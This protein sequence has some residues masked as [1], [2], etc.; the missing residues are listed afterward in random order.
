MRKTCP[1]NLHMGY[2]VGLSAGEQIATGNREL[3]Q[4]D[5]FRRLEFAAS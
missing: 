5:E 4:C 3:T 2:L 1:G